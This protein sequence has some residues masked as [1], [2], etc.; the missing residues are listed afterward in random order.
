MPTDKKMKIQICFDRYEKSCQ[1][2][3]LHLIKINEI[4]SQKAFNLN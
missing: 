2:F 1:G 3:N 4:S